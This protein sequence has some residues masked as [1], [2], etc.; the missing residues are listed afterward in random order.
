M[1]SYVP[2][3]SRGRELRAVLGWS[4]SVSGRNWRCCGWRIGLP[5]VGDDDV[6]EGGVSAPE[7]GEA[8][9]DDHDVCEGWVVADEVVAQV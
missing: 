7:A 4:L 5:G 6:V 8:D 9:F 3:T 1:G 2:M